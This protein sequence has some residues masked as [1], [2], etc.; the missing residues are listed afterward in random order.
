MPPPQAAGQPQSANPN[1]PFAAGGYQAN[2]NT[3]LN[4]SGQPM[5]TPG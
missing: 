3:S 4:M 5:Y 2:E 1:N